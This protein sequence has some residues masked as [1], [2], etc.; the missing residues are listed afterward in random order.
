MIVKY[1]ALIV[2]G[3]TIVA[4]WLRQWRSVRDPSD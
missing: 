4:I 2:A 3:L 1:G